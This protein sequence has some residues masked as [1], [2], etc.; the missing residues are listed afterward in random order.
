MPS[1]PK[2]DGN[3]R[4]PEPEKPGLTMEVVLPKGTPPAAEPDY[5]EKPDDEPTHKKDKMLQRHGVPPQT[6]G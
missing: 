4:A 2:K 5:Q 3:G 1:D 6:T